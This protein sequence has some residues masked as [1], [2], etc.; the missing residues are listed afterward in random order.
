MVHVGLEERILRFE[1]GV[2]E[3][4]P[5]MIVALAEALG[6]DPMRLLLLPNG[7]DLEALRLASGR[8]A[9]DLAHSVHVSLRAYLNWESGLDLPL[10]DQRILAALARELGVSTAQIVTALRCHAAD[11]A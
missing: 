2:N 9:A 4:N 3:P 6:V 7:I 10:E 5:R 11:C 8:G 1:R